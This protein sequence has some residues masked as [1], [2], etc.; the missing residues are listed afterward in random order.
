MDTDTASSSNVN[1]V[2][3]NNTIG[4]NYRDDSYNVIIPITPNIDNYIGNR[5]YIVFIGNKIPEEPLNADHQTIINGQNFTNMGKRIQAL[6]EQNKCLKDI[7][8]KLQQTVE[9]LEYMP[10]GPKYQEALEDFNLNQ[11]NL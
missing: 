2:S 9:I 4:S 1:V 8:T 3:G 6:E 11:K 7:I 5:N 10:G